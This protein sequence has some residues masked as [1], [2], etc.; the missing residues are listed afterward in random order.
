MSHFL[1][2]NF[3]FCLFQEQTFR[4]IYFFIALILLEFIVRVICRIC[5]ITSITV[6]LGVSTVVCLADGWPSVSH[7]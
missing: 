4:K 3:Q 6:H 7:P 1:L 5:R 2:H